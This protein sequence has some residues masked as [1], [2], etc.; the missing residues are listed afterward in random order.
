MTRRER[1]SLL[2]IGDDP[3]NLNLR[4]ALLKK[5]GWQVQSSGCG[6]DGVLRF[7][8]APVDLVVID[9]DRDGAEAAL[10][11]SELKRLRQ[12]VRVLMLVTDHRTL[13]PGATRQADAV[14]AKA[15]EGERL[16]EALEKLERKN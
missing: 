13:A 10:I 16:V 7:Q 12:G 2:C 11:I 1:G 5:N 3:V 9:L 8:H 14:V 4:C 15:E 6:H